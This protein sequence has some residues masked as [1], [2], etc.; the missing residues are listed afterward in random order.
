M[1]ESEKSLLPGSSCWLLDYGSRSSSLVK[2]QR[3]DFL[4]EEMGSTKY[5]RASGWVCEVPFILNSL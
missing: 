1:L 5:S 2:R 3:T 4:D